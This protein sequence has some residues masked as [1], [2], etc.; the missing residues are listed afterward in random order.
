MLRGA[1]R[2]A[3]V[4][5]LSSGCG[6]VGFSV[7]DGSI[8]ASW[9]D[10]ASDF[11]YAFVKTITI[12]RARI[13]GAVCGETLADYPLL[14]S[15]TDTD[16]RDNVMD[17]E[18]DDIIFVGTNAAVCTGLGPPP[19]A[20]DHEIER[21]DPGSGELVAWVRIPS[22]NTTAAG[23]D[24]TIEIHYGDA[25]V[26]TAT[27]NVARVWDA[28]HVGV[29]H[30]SEDPGPAGP[31]DIRDSTARGN[32]GTA[33]ASMTAV[34]QVPGRVGGS[35]DF[36][37]IDDHVNAGANASLD[38]GA[39]DFSVS[40]WF[41]TTGSEY[42][43]AGKGG[44]DGGGRRFGLR[45]RTRGPVIRIDD[46]VL[47]AVQV[48]PSTVSND[49]TWHRATGVRDGD[50]LRLYVD[51]GEVPASPRDISGYGSLDSPR[52]ALIGAIQQM[53]SGNP[54][55]FFLGLIDEVRISD[56][57]RNACWIGANY[58]NQSLPGD[59]GSPGFYAVGTQRAGF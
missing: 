26:T 14:Y 23:S 3:C 44:N 30:L 28:N 40:A 11:G 16:L 12:D 29:W 33:H 20:L 43:I 34:D 19:C 31:G 24:T 13:D 45:V 7:A 1:V 50:N 37:G 10:A 25:S 42:F 39:G 57:A 59:I 9:V 22:L 48:S 38:M 6:R 21:W 53:E 32:H 47:A 27:Q 4:L 54:G 58:E 51:G 8:D 17:P 41:S 18:G 55:T 36:D 15:V 35:L 49:G 46:D 5:V 56:V 52:D 2:L